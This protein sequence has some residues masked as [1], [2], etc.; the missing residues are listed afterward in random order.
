MKAGEFL[1][2]LKDHSYQ[3]DFSAKTI[4]TGDVL[5][6]NIKGPVGIRISNVH[7]ER[8]VTIEGIINCSGV[9]LSNCDFDKNLTLSHIGFSNEKKD[10]PLP[11]PSK[12]R[13]ASKAG[14]SLFDCR[15]KNYLHLKQFKSC[16]GI[17]FLRVR[18]EVVINFGDITLQYLILNNVFTHLC[19]ILNCQVQRA[20]TLTSCEINKTLFIDPLAPEE[21]FIKACNFPGVCKFVDIHPS[22]KFEFQ[23]SV[24]HRE[25]A[26]PL[27]NNNDCSL[28]FIR[29]EFK[30]GCRLQYLLD[31]NDCDENREARGEITIQEGNYGPGLYIMGGNLGYKT[32]LFLRNISIE[33]T[34]GLSGKIFVYDTRILLTSLFGFSFRSDLLFFSGVEM[35]SLYMENFSCQ[36]AGSTQFVRCR[37]RKFSGRG[38]TNLKILESKPGSL[39]FHS[40]DMSECE[41]VSIVNND[42]SG[43]QFVNVKWFDLRKLIP[44]LDEES[45]LISKIRFRV[46]M[47]FVNEE[48]STGS[49]ESVNHSR[50]AFRQL[51]QA[52]EKQ[53]DRARALN[54]QQYEMKLF[55]RELRLTKTFFNQDRFIIWLSNS[56]NYGQSWTK[57]VLL[58]LVL[59]AVFW[60]FIAKLSYPSA[61]FFELL[62][63]RNSTYVQMLN[64]VHAI[65]KILPG[66][67]E[68]PD[69]VWWL[70]YIHRLI[71]AYLIFQT[72]SAFRK[73]V[74]G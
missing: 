34:E 10:D 21:F 60:L 29:L 38:E 40:V 64:P 71:L 45:S 30:K 28:N 37:I 33:A 22:K 39:L 43:L 16:P 72:V 24:F 11:D 69:L 15:I 6:A 36:S 27:K 67:V 74:R 66:A 3:L 61:S 46:K 2:K 49:A 73:F 23:D 5:I 59:T 50:E 52:A 42:L 26:L 4:V 65:D 55:N 56:N 19:N 70:D 41:T 58:L 8:D 14:L 48:D 12:G 57:P 18:C 53:G 17:H 20:I 13:H 25:F 31:E 54:F 32:S 44:K 47:L 62:S 68:I 35:R 51:R 7:F 9:H 1:Q 63:S